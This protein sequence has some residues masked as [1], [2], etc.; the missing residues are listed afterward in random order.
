M[1]IE[2]LL[3]EELK[4]FIDELGIDL[5]QAVETALSQI[6]LFTQS[7]LL[8]PTPDNLAEQGQNIA[9]VVNQLASVAAI[10]ESRVRTY[11]RNAVATVVADIG[12]G[13]VAAIV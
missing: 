7:G 10:E 3:R 12:K 5:A 1:S 13:L 6:S 8:N 4:D 9:H 2:D 11:V